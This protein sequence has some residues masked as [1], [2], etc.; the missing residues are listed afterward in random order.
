MSLFRKRQMWERAETTILSDRRASGRR[1]ADPYPDK[2]MASSC[3]SYVQGSH[4]HLVTR[5]Q[6][7]K[8]SPLCGMLGS[9]SFWL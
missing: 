6:P 3:F 5:L 9:E 7:F 4:P 2:T 8:I 1:Q